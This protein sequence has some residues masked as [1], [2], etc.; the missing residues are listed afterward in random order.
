MSH[1][2]S[3]YAWVGSN[4]RQMLLLYANHIGQYSSPWEVSDSFHW[5]QGKLQG[6]I[7]SKEIFMLLKSI[8][9]LCHVR[10]LFPVNQPDPSCFRIFLKTKAS[11]VPVSESSFLKCLSRRRMRRRPGPCSCCQRLATWST[12]KTRRKLAHASLPYSCSLL[13]Y[14]WVISCFL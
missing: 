14:S 5:K 13:G 3:T 8:V 7:S 12:K 11:A 4:P 10:F 9:S 1:L 6:R 2:F